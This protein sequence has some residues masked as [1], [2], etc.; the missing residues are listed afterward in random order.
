MPEQYHAP[1]CAD[2]SAFHHPRAPDRRLSE[3][4]Q[5]AAEIAADHL[6]PA[7]C[8][9]LDRHRHGLCRHVQHG[10]LSIWR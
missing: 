7:L 4:D 9:Q 2:R 3:R 10:R 6:L 1:V 5:A 8:H